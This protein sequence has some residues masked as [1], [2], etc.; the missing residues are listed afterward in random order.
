MHRVYPLRLAAAFVQQRQ[1]GQH[2]AFGIVFARLRG[3]EGGQ[4]AVAGVLQHAAFVALHNIGAARQ[5]AV[6]HVL[7]VLGRQALANA[8]AD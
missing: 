1:A 3:T 5:G 6:H 2:G 4:Q 8:D 7:N